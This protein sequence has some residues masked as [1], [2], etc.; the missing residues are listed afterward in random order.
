MKHRGQKCD[1]CGRRYPRVFWVTY[2]NG[3]VDVCNVCHRK[4]AN[5]GVNKRP[6]DLPGQRLRP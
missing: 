4:I 3:T 6:R 2:A 1:L 5:G